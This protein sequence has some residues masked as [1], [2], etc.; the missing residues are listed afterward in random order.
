MSKT[1]RVYPKDSK[2]EAKQWPEEDFQLSAQTT[3]EDFLH[4]SDPSLGFGHTMGLNHDL[5][6]LTAGGAHP[7]LHS[8]L[9]PMGSYEH[10]NKFNFHDFQVNIAIVEHQW[11]N[12]GLDILN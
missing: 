11:T 1:L 8:D 3:H 2:S 5:F 12:P 9:M 10:Q 4:P 7:S 6:K